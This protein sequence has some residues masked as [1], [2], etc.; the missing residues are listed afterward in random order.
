MSGSIRNRLVGMF[1]LVERLF[2]QPTYTA[3]RCRVACA[4]R[5]ERGCVLVQKFFG[6]YSYLGAGVFMNQAVVGN[7]CL[8]PAARRSAEWSILDVGVAH[9]RESAAK[10]SVPR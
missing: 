10:L 5:L 3:R 2:C 1:F 8:S 4:S 9:R 6:T 7:Y